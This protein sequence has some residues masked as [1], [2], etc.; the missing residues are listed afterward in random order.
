MMK[1]T[2]SILL[3]LAMLVGNLPILAAADSQEHPYVKVVE[4]AMKAGTGGY[5]MLYDVD[6]NGTDELLM[7]Y[8][9]R[10]DSIPAG[11]YSIHTLSGDRAVPLVSQTHMFYEVG[12]PG[13][14][15]GVVEKDGRRFVA[16]EWS[17]GYVEAYTHSSSGHWVL[18]AVD[19]ES[20]RVDTEVSY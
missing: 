9:A 11:V 10:T 15:I 13:G 7:I 16:V 4:Q 3:V 18:Y 6:G 19:G 14:S 1:R 8:N 2:L 17:N 5:G 20:V 12:A